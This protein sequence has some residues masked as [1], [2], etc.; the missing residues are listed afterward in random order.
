MAEQG[1]P[2]M[3]ALHVA[4]ED[5]A[6]TTKSTVALPVAAFS[7]R[8]DDLVARLKQQVAQDGEDLGDATHAVQY[9]HESLFGP[10]GFRVAPGSMDAFRPY[11]IYMHKVLTQRIGTQPALG[12][13]FASFVLRARQAGIV[14][15]F[16]VQ[17]RLSGG[18]QVPDARVAEADGDAEW[19]AC[20]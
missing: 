11:R 9:L 16:D 8:L 4:A 14:G 7:K 19:C 1:D 2:V 13:L 15:D 5:D 12:A 6:V 20:C 18:A 17:I 10:G 3:A